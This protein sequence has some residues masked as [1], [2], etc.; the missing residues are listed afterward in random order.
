MSRVCP[1]AK[2]AAAH[3]RRA[4]AAALAAVL[5]TVV[6]LPTALG[7]IECYVCNS[8]DT[9]EWVDKPDA[10]HLKNCSEMEKGSMYTACRKMD[11]NV[12]FPVNGLPEQK[13]VVRQ[14]AVVGEP[15]RPCYYKAGFGGRVNVCHCFDNKCNGAGLPGLAGA[16]VLALPL[17]IFLQRG[18]L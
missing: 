8:K 3:A 12:D 9:P 17:L 16:A 7:A 5:L 4:P 11:I 18:H 2:T 14:C 10:S 6:Y 15:D 1:T 13:R